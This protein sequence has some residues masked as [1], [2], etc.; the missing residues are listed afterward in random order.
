MR[1]KRP[2][3]RLKR[4]SLEPAA[5]I[6]RS[7]GYAFQDF[8]FLAGRAP[9]AVGRGVKG[10][11]MGM[12]LRTRQRLALAVLGSGV[13]AAALAF[14]VPRLPCEFPGGDVCAPMDDIDALVPADALGYVHLTL[15]PESS[16]YQEA[17]QALDVVPQLTR[18]LVGRVLAQIPGPGGEPADFA[19]DIAPWLGGQA[20]VAIVPLGGGAEQVQLLEEGDPEGAGQ[21]AESLA[22][23]AAQT[24]DYR[25]IDVS[26][27]SRGLATASVEGY[28]VIGTEEG[29]SRV[30]DV[31]T[32][33]EDSRSLAEEQVAGD[34]RDALP[35][36]RFAEAYVSRDGIEALIEAQSSPLSF[37][38]PF[39]DAAASEAAAASVGADD[40]SLELAIRS[41]LDP[42]RAR[43]NPGFFAAFPAFDPTIPERLAKNTLGY[44]GIAEPGTTVAELLAQATA[45]APALAEGF[46]EAAERLRDLG[47]VEIEDELLPSL[48][49]EAAFALKPGDEDRPAPEPEEATTAPVPEGLPQGPAPAADEAP[50]PVLQFLA[51]GVDADRAKRTLAQLQGPIAEALDPGTSLQA[52]VFGREELEGVDVQILR[53]SPTVN[54]SYAIAGEDLAIATQ[55]EGVEAVIRGE[56]GLDANDGF[57]AVTEGLAD[58]PSLIVFLDLAGLIDLAEREGLAEDPAY[59]LFAPEA[60]R[61][62]AAGLTVAAEPAS[63]DTDLRIVIDQDEEDKGADEAATPSE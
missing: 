62:R 59:A 13:A 39:V 61:L 57:S 20:G 6:L 32:G 54:L 36:T 18:Q 40:G 37:L 45:E 35:P 7:A 11:W 9:R 8:L 49:G 25:G 33:A 31:A 38:E 22:A 51:E 42:E 2:S 55:P 21:F 23:G 56:G 60:R 1:L 29:V 63:I 53:I 44:V 10:F 3:L 28:R 50:V 17:T 43:S 12:S 30:I 47:D 14:A 16:Q 15:D 41:A 46:T 58:D 4:P 19:R 34:L 27:D 26:T 24:A 52:P 5:R 48:G